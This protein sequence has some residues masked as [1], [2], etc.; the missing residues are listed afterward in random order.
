MP[1]WA[2]FVLLDAIYG[3]AQRNRICQEALAYWESVIYTLV[4]ANTQLD[5]YCILVLEQ[6]LKRQGFAPTEEPFKKLINQGMI[7]GTRVCV[8]LYQKQFK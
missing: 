3:C 4:E 1:G 6:I 5:I 8:N 2:K 7:L